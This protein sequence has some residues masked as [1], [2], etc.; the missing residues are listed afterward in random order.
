MTLRKLLALYEE[1][2]IINGLNEEAADPDE[3]TGYI[4][5]VM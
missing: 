4:D 2:K 1:H 5:Q 3:P